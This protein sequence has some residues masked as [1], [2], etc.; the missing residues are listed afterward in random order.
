MAIEKIIGIVTDVV[1]HSDKHNVVTLYTRDHGRVALLSAAGSGKMARVRNASLMPLSVISADINFVA[2]REL[3]FLGK[4][5]REILWKHIYFNPV[6]SAIGMF[7]SE[8]IN[9]YVRQSPPDPDMWDYM[10][11]AISTLDSAGRGVAN[12]H[13]AFL[14]DMLTYAGIRPD[15]PREGEDNW[16]D[17][18]AGTMTIFPP[19][20]RNTLTPSQAEILTTLSRL[21][22]RT[23]RV[24]HFTGAQRRELL[25][26]I[27]TYYSLHYPGL[28]NLKSPDILSEIFAK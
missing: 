20:H 19:R 11:R 6:K 10:V 2:T 24:F 1:K 13:L 25:N 17:M 16:F 9:C 14:I 23:Y 15:L 8:F 12:L 21:N 27:L 22:L 4:F 7:I 26:G 28:N 18:Q 5:T 3:Q